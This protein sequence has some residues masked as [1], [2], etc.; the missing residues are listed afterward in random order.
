MDINGYE[1]F[2]AVINCG[3]PQGSVLGPILF[4]L[5]IND[6]NQAIKFC[7]VH[8]FADD[9]NLLCSSNSINKPNKPRVEIRI[10]NMSGHKKN[11]IGKANKRP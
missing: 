2:L 10:F 8:H 11:D 3:V 9:T 4:L 1:S 6:L 5:Y 7:K